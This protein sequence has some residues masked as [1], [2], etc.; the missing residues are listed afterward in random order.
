[1][2]ITLQARSPC[3]LC[4]FRF[5]VLMMATVRINR[6]SMRTTGPMF[7]TSGER[8]CPECGWPNR[9]DS[10]PRTVYVLDSRSAAAVGEYR[11][12]KFGIEPGEIAMERAS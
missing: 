9:S 1:M 8:L 7:G 10:S 4:G 3:A 2:R 5:R 11:K 12:R 6:R